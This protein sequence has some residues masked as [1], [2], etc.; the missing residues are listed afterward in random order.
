ML[1]AF[2]LSGCVAALQV[3]ATN[4]RPNT[5]FTTVAPQSLAL[6]LDPSILDSVELPSQPNAGIVL[7]ST[8]R[9]LINGYMNGLGVYFSPVPAGRPADLALD[10]VKADFQ[11]SA[12]NDRWPALQI[13]YKAQLIG[14]DGEIMAVAAGTV[15][16]KMR[17]SMDDGSEADCERS[18]VES[19]YEQLASE[20]VRPRVPTSVAS[21]VS[22]R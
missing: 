5:P 19:L 2:T 18:A 22:S 15:S 4:P 20:L 14:R 21:P 16:S 9:T 11:W 6:I 1:A 3:A 10:I 17:Y 12:W 8:R 13:V 7:T